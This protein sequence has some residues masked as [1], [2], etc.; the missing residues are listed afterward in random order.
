M[1]QTIDTP[2]VSALSCFAMRMETIIFVL[3]LAVIALSLMMLARLI[4]RGEMS[5]R[6]LR[7]GPTR[8]LHEP[9]VVYLIGTYLIM[10]Y[11]ALRM[12]VSSGAPLEL[13]FALELAPFAMIGLLLGRARVAEAGF[14]KIGLLPRHPVRDLRWGLM[15]GIVGYGVAGLSAI[16]VILL[17]NYLGEPAPEVAHQALVNL[18]EDFN[19]SRLILLIISAVIAAPLIEELVFRGVL[20]TSLMRLLK[21]QRWPAMV[22]TALVFSAIHAWAVPTHGLVP[23]FVLGLVFGYLYERTG[24]LITPILAH[25]V[26]NAVNIAIA[27]SMPEQLPQ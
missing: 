26:F 7:L 18:Q 25:A 17:F 8:D 21:G 27:L 6:Y 16:S 12:Q 4:W 13:Q 9:R 19:L 10:G 20:Q 5:E 23:L 24:S 1:A 2:T 22:I 15:G 11:A 3:Q 14:R